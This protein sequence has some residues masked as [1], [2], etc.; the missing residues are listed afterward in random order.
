MAFVQ[1]TGYSRSRAYREL[2]GL[3]RRGI[4]IKMGTPHSPYY[5]LAPD[6]EADATSPS[7]TA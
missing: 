6:H 4:L 5:R 7:P 3:V 1:A 2:P